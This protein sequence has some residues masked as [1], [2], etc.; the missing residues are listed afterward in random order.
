MFLPHGTAVERRKPCSSCCHAL[1]P[2][3]PYEPLRIVKVTERPNNMQAQ[4][5]LRLNEVSLEQRNQQV[6]ISAV[7]CVWSQLE[8]RSFL[9][10]HLRPRSSK[11]GPPERRK[12]TTCD[13]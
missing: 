11:V 1:E 6:A 7:K 2:S 5:F 12:L 4:F 3:K 10:H 9:H 13:G 8:Y